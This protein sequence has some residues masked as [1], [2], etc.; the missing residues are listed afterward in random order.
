MFFPLSKLIIAE[1]FYKTE[2]FGRPK[3]DKSNLE[4]GID[5][6][7]RY[8]QPPLS[9]RVH[10]LSATTAYATHKIRTCKPLR[11][12]GIQSRPL[13][14]QTRSIFYLQAPQAGVDPARHFCPVCFRNSPL[15][16]LG[17]AAH[18]TACRA[19][20]GIWRLKSSYPRRSGEGSIITG[21]MRFELI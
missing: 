15:C 10:P 18:D 11:A 14:A 7:W 13:T 8:R 5:P 4:Q 16:R 6:P 12:S 9:K 3:F 17:T 19:R 21:I 1:K 20:T 2:L